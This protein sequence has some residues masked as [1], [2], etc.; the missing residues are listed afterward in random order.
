LLRVYEG[1]GL[2]KD[3]GV[4][5]CYFTLLLKKLIFNSDMNHEM[6]ICKE[7]LLVSL[8]FLLIE[9]TKP[10]LLNFKKVI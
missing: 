9:R 10:L 5:T 1:I 7:Y 3:E 8:Q 6:W 4:L 2:C